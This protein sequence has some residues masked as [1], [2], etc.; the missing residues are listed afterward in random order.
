MRVLI[1]AAALAA[2][3]LGA[4]S[5]SCGG[6]ADKDALAKVAGSYA[7]EEPG[8]KSDPTHMQFT[9]ARLKGV[10]R[11]ESQ[12][13]LWFTQDD[14]TLTVAVLTADCGVQYRPGLGPDAITQAALPAKPPSL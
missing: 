12:T 8:Q 3:S 5:K 6:L 7:A 2:A 9:A 13:Q 14:G 1:V 4:C 11:G 10:G